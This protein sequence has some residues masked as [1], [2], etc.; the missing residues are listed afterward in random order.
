[1]LILLLLALSPIALKLVMGD[2]TTDKT[3]KRW[4]FFLCGVCIVFVM[5][6]RDR[7]TG[8]TDTD[9]YCRVFDSIARYSNFKEYLTKS[10]LFEDGLFFSEAGFSFFVFF[11]TRIFSDAQALIFF[12]SLFITVCTLLFI[13][14]NSLSPAMSILMYITL[15]LFTFNMNGMRQAMA[16]SVCALAYEHVKNKKL[17]KFLVTVFFAMMFHKTA[18]FFAL[19][20]PLS[21]MKLKFSHVVVFAAV[22]GAFILFAN[23]FVSIFDDLADK[24]YSDSEAVEGGGF[25]TVA[26][27][28]LVIGLSLF[29][30]RD[31]NKENSLLL[32]SLS[33]VGLILYLA[34]YF[35]IQI[36]ERM[37]YYFFYALLILLP[38][39][40]SNFDGKSR[41]LVNGIIAL[42]SL[43]LLMY[44]INGSVFDGFSLIF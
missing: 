42:L 7:F 28:A 32:L 29:F 15:G 5:G 35:S 31:W 30:H 41:V 19:V 38:I 2:V 10:K 6:F 23:R 24:N 13:W 33:M 4:Y 39:F 16:M 44:R 9:N 26:I 12:S 1:M 22:L 18:I 36:Y 17:G 43:F 40:V 27:Y 21:G 14:K 11:L 20:Y 3:K 25:I 34:R 37:S 8:T